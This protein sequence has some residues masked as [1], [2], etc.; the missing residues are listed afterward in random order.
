MYIVNN[1]EHTMISI[2]LSIKEARMVKAAL[3]QELSKA[4]TL[5]SGRDILSLSRIQGDLV[6]QVACAE[7]TAK[8]GV[9]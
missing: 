7:A 4:S 1:K 5:L 6:L 3:G 9:K 8:M 2:S